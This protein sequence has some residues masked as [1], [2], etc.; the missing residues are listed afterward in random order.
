[1]AASAID[2]EVASSDGTVAPAEHLEALLAGQLPMAL[3]ALASSGV[4]GQ[5][6]DAGGVAPARGRVNRTDLA[7]E[8]VGDLD[9]DAGAV[10]GVLLGSRWLRGGPGAPGP[11]GLA[12]QGVGGTAL[13]V[14]HQGHAAGVVLEPYKPREGSGLVVNGTSP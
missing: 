14:G 11:R 10:A 5:E 13:Q 3:R 4:A 1:M 9:E 2:P 6:G 8:V 7:I 12:D